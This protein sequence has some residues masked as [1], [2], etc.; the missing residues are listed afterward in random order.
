[1]VGLTSCEEHE[2]AN[3]QGPTTAVSG[4]QKG[5]NEEKHVHNSHLGQGGREAFKEG[6]MLTMSKKAL[7]PLAMGAGYGRNTVLY[8]VNS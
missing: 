1:M 4:W 5:R 3:W 8:R 2:H 7:T 6:N